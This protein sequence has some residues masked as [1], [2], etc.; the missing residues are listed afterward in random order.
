M[1]T[2]IPV[3]LSSTPGIVDNSNATAITIDSSEDVTLAGHIALTDSKNIKL[4]AGTDLQLYHDGTNS[5]ITNSTG[6]ITIDAQG[7]D[8][9][10]IFKGTD[11]STDI[12]ALTLD[13]SAEGRANF[14]SHAILETAGKYLQVTG[15]SSNAWAF[16][17]TGGNAT[18]G[19]GSTSLGVHHWNG[20]AWSIPLEITTTGVATLL[21]T[22]AGDALTLKSTEAGASLGPSLN[23]YRSSGSPADGDILGTI[24]F[25]GESGGSGAHTYGQIRME[26]NGVTD[27]QEQGKMIFDISMPDGDLAQA[28]QV[29]R[30]EIA[31]NESAED[32][33]FRAESV[34]HPYM[35]YLDAGNNRVGINLPTAKVTA[36]DVPA[37]PFEAWDDDEVTRL[38]VANN[39]AYVQRYQTHAT[40]PSTL[41]FD[42]ARGTV[43]SPTTSSNGDDLG[44]ILFRGYTDN[45]MYEAASIHAE[46]HSAGIGS[47]SD[48]PGDL[49]FKTTADG[50]TATE[51]MRLNADGLWRGEL[52]NNSNTNPLGS[53][54][55]SGKLWCTSGNYINVWQVTNDAV[56]AHYWIEIDI[57]SLD[58]YTSYGEIYKDRNGR[59]RIV[60]HR[61]AGTNFQVS[62]DNN[63][64]QVT[65]SSGADQTNSSGNLKLVRIPGATA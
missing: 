65:Q 62:S 8:T 47:G 31:V 37:H 50:G 41:V 43:D 58:G 24:K 49:Y 59:W 18:P 48:I 3:E 39:A 33:N 6:N 23:L 64:I 54:T 55:N 56:G 45:G 32:L 9:D 61:Q 26:N 12:T 36:G 5:Y 19:T 10:I 63:Y 4:G 57:Q 17:S 51:R 20:S 44:R 2:K 25:T 30:T 15:S 35:L 34:N 1:T 11:D 13:M 14:N 52:L 22:A 28:F 40:A 60:Q 16:G 42:K 7:S 46:V 38:G 21:T 53:G 27:G 29:G